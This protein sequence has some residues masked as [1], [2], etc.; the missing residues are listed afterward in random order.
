MSP[1]RHESEQIPNVE[2]KIAPTKYATF[3]DRAVDKLGKYI[4][5]D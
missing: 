3:L 4:V 1:T 5:K 2:T